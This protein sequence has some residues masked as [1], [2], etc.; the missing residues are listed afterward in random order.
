MRKGLFRQSVCASFFLQLPPIMQR[1][2]TSPNHQ[3][4]FNC[5]CSTMSSVFISNVDD[6]L[7]PS[8]ACVNP[9]FADSDKKQ[10]EKKEEPAA[11]VVPKRRRVMRKKRSLLNGNDAA[12]APA[13]P[14]TPAKVTM[15]DCLACSGCVTTAE[16]VLVEQH[17]LAT[18][19]QALQDDAPRDVV[20]TISPASWADLVR[21]LGISPSLSLKRRLTTF[22]YN[23]CRAS[24]VLDGRLPLEWS[25]QEAAR[26]FCHAHQRRHVQEMDIPPPSMALS[27]NSI[28]YTNGTIVECLERPESRIPLLTSSCPA[29][30][31]LVEK[32]TAA[33][34]PHL[35]TTKSPMAMAGAYMKQSST[36]VYHV[37]V[38]PCHDKKLE[39]SRKDLQEDSKPDVDLVIT[40]SEL[41]TL[42]CETVGRDDVENIVGHLENLPMAPVSA[43][44]SGLADHLAGGTTLVV[45]SL[46]NNDG[47]VEMMNTCDDQ[48][49]QDFFAHGSGGY[50][51]YIFRFASR[52]LFGFEI[53]GELPW[54]PVETTQGRRVVSARVAASSKK[55][56]DYHQVV[57][58]QHAD[59]SF[60]CS[61]QSP[62]DV[63]VLRFATAYGLQNIQRV[64]QYAPF[65][66]TSSPALS[67]DY[68]EAMACPSGCPNGGGQIREANVRET[69]T[70]TRERVTKTNQVMKESECC[71]SLASL[72]YPSD[73]CPSG[74]FGQEAKR[75]LHTRFHVVPPLQHTMGAAAGVAVQDTQW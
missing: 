62:Q 65:S 41:W 25:L 73:L 34:V 48:L 67:F 22:L 6:Y 11:V 7:A 9:M 72:G 31:C 23:T 8:Q 69:P 40:T 35:S 43:A 56:R 24:V 52:H 39:A 16:T 14:S 55:R 53:Q 66:T 49:S 3:K 59:G 61:R 21:K 29:L 64:L 1:A 2:T 42:L 12:E 19:K 74:P 58:Y 51:D 70:E 54:A 26:E 13:I 18:L 5:S 57:L 30:V 60:S 15:A 37:A 44:I 45:P 50:A 20:M 38:M 63:S 28:Q 32:S 10:D 75:L 33:A 27:N 47:D 46:E 71:G 68:V 36:N 17:S 4:H